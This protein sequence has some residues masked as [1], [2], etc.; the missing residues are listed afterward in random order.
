[1]RVDDRG[2]RLDDSKYITK[3]DRNGLFSLIDGFPEQL[4]RGL[5]SFPENKIFRSGDYT[6]I[7]LVGLGTSRVC[8]EL[9]SAVISE[10][11]NLPVISLHDYFLPHWVGKS[12]L[13]IFLSFSGNTE[14]VISCFQQSLERKCHSIV[15]TAGGYLGEKAVAEGVPLFTIQKESPPNRTVFP[16]MIV[17]V[18]LYC[19]RCGFFSMREGELKQTADFLKSLRVSLTIK[20]PAASNYAKKIALHLYKKLP[21]I[22]ADDARFRAVLLRW[23]YQLNENAK[24]LAYS[25]YLP[26][27]SHNEMMGLQGSDKLS[28]VSTIF[29]TSSDK[30]KAILE[31][32]ATFTLSVLAE[33]DCSLLEVPLQGSGVLQKLFYGIFLGD[34]AS[35]YLAVLRGKNPQEVDLIDKIRMSR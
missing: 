20:S 26:E 3:I 14:E 25:A 6:S 17:P 5:K 2:N 19:W 15:V 35:F 13:L 34:Y 1:M 18:L 7:G 22:Y 4:E 27:M 32:R 31:K 24:S 10:S 12:T 23:Q 8:A 9:L 21:L 16:Y 33:T 30:R 28:H 29:I 11:G